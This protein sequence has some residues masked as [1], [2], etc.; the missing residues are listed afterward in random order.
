M[1]KNSKMAYKAYKTAV[2]AVAAPSDQWRVACEVREEL[3]AQ[4]RRERE[5]LLDYSDEALSCLSFLSSGDVAQYRSGSVGGVAVMTYEDYERFIK[6]RTRIPNYT[7][8]EGLKVAPEDIRPATV[9]NVRRCDT[10]LVASERDNSTSESVIEADGRRVSR[11]E[12]SDTTL[13]GSI[14]RIFDKYFPGNTVVTPGRRYRKRMSS[15]VAGMAWVAIFAIMLALPITLSVLKSETSADMI[16]MKDTLEELRDEIDNLGVE[17]DSKNDL[18]V[19][20]DIAVNEYGMISINES[21][22]HL[23][24]LNDIDIIESFENERDTGVVP[25]LLSALGIRIGGE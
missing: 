24:R 15:A 22:M 20:E 19:I 17:L 11:I 4:L 5:S 25:A 23:L 3:E 7:I 12:S 10:S 6:E 9:F 21:T 16:E 1:K 2:E 8:S 14:L 13:T 18:R